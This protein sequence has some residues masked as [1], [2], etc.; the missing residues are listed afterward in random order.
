V[1]YGQ[2]SQQILFARLQIHYFYLEDYVRL[3]NYTSIS[4]TSIYARTISP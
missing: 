3:Y 1:V 2:I 4:I